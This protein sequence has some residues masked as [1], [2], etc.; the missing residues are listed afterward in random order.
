MNLQYILKPT[1]NV[2]DRYTKEIKKNITIINFNEEPFLWINWKREV[3][4]IVKIKNQKPS[5]I[6]K[7]KKELQEIYNLKEGEV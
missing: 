3:F 2:V 7:F 6:N 5:T 4:K 1:I